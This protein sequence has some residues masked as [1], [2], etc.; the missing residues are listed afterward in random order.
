MEQTFEYARAKFL[1]DTAKYF[2]RRGHIALDF[3]LPNREKLIDVICIDR[4]LNG[5]HFINTVEDIEFIK[6][7]INIYRGLFEYTAM[8]L[9]NPELY[10][11]LTAVIPKSITVI[12]YL[13]DRRDFVFYEMGSNSNS[14]SIE[15]LAGLLSQDEIIQIL[16]D[17]C[18]KNDYSNFSMHELIGRLNHFY[19]V[20]EFYIQLI[21]FLVLRRHGFTENNKILFEQYTECLDS[22]KVDAPSQFEG[23]GK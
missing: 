5:F 15:S 2:N 14:I 3:K 4:S 18:E 17:Y 8:V 13:P 23:V 7:K 10:E 1:L 16:N 21:S 11:K 19:T 9:I 12:H 6:N 22:N 20:D